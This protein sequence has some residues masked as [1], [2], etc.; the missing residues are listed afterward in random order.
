MIELCM[1]FQVSNGFGGVTT[2][3]NGLVVRISF[4]VLLLWIET[5]LYLRLKS[6]K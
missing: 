4:S 5:I 6:G 1:N 3:D 2:L